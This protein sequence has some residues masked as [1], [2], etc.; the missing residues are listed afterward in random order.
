[1]ISPPV[2][3]AV[4]DDQG[5]TV[6]GFTGSVTIA[7]EHD[8]SPFQNAHLSGTRVVNVVNGIATFADLSI[9]EPGMGYTLRATANPLTGATSTPF[10]VTIP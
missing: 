9:D 2:Q 6:L 7:L 3:V 5:N 1:V 4:V 10:N 8:G